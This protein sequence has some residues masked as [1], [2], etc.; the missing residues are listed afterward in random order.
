MKFPLVRR[1]KSEPE[2]VAAVEKRIAALEGA[3]NLHSRTE[4][5]RA[6]PRNGLVAEVRTYLG[7]DA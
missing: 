6:H 4:F 3:L 5:T 1:G 7:L 2:R